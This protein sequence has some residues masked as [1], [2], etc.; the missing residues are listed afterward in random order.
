MVAAFALTDTFAA[1]L[2]GSL[3]VPTVMSTALETVTAAY[4]VPP[5]SRTSKA[6]QTEAGRRL[7]A[8]QRNPNLFDGVISRAPALQLGGLH[9]R[10][11][12]YRQGIGCSRWSVQCRKN[13]TAGQHVRDAC[14]GLDGIVDGVGFE[15]R[16]CPATVAN[17]AALRCA[18]GADT[19]D[20]CLSDAQLAVVKSW[21]SD[22]IYRGSASFR[23]RG[24]NL[25]GNE[26]DPMGFGRWVSGDGD[27][28]KALQ[29]IFQDT[30]YKY[31]FARDAT[32]TRSRTRPGTRTRT[33]SLQWRRSMTLHKPISD[34]SGQWRQADR[35]ARRLRCRTQRQLDHR[36]LQ[37]RQDH[38]G[39]CL[40]RR[41][42][43]VLRCAWRQ[44]LCR[45]SR[46]RQCGFAQRARWLGGERQCARDPYSAKARFHGSRGILP[47]S[48]SAPAVSALHRTC[49]RCCGSKTGRELHVLVKYRCSRRPAGLTS[50]GSVTDRF[51]VSVSETAMGRVAGR[52]SPCSPTYQEDPMPR[53]P[54][55]RPRERGELRWQCMTGRMCSARQG[56]AVA[57]TAYSTS[58]ATTTAMNRI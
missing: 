31:Y 21:T 37:K 14:D 32:P 53:L 58:A 24:Y 23:S 48:V 55:Q 34:R 4:G 36:V 5:A 26:D 1:Q 7:M 27:F 39:R 51:R 57:A 40:D 8:V 22:A 28:R 44:P 42:R 47:A 38:R 2:F 13:D 12:P 49:K 20:T 54:S 33:R 18:G 17:A 41:L 6:A 11:Q 46:G 50:G 3:S 43:A 52:T 19:G 45:R 35:L 29:Y 30:T 25:T 9:G 15:S 16:G 56:R 10:L